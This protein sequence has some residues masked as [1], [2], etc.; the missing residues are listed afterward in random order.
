MMIGLSLLVCCAS[1]LAQEWTRFRGPNGTGEASGGKGIPAQFTAADYN[2]RTKLPGIG[3]SSPVVWGD[4]IFLM[5]ADPDTATRYVLCIGAADGKI[6]WQRD[7]SS[8]PH[9]LHTRSSFASCT[10]AVDEERVYVAW[11]TPAK[12]SFMAFTHGG[13]TVWDLDLGTW[14]SQHGFGASPIVYQDLVILFNSQQ[15]NQLKEGEKPGQSF[16]MAFDKK[17]GKEIWRRERVSVNVCYSVPCIM[18]GDSGDEL[19]CTSTGDGVFSLNP[20]TGEENWKIDVFKMRTVASPILAGGHVFGSTGSGQGGNYIVAVKPGKNPE[21]AFRI[22]TQA[23]YVPTLISYG[24]LVFSWF[25]GGIVTCFDAKTGERYWQNR[26][27][28]SFSGSPIRVDDR[29]YCINDDG[30]VFCV[31]CDKEFKPLGESPLEEASRST[32]AVSGGRLYLR[33]YSHLISVG[34]KSS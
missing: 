8:E 33:T 7:F 13:E 2:W 34:G 4:K 17:S 12:T 24:D 16:M 19:I 9:H 27:G 15:A 25:D 29:M 21:E 6:L 3:H 30:V 22:K 26:M 11:S 5:S 18:Q 31:A 1:T 28:A 10:P 14:Q 23:S 20:R 32:P